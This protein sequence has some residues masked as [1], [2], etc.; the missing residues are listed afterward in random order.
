MTQESDALQYILDRWVNKFEM[1]SNKEMAARLGSTKSWVNVRGRLM[2]DGKLQASDIYEFEPTPDVIE[3]YKKIHAQIEKPLPELVNSPD[4]FVPVSIPLLGTVKAGTNGFEELV[5]D[6]DPSGDSALLPDVS[7]GQEVYSLAVVGNSM[8]TDHILPDDLL[9]V[10]RVSSAEVK[11]N[12]LIVT[13]Y[14]NEQ[15][16][17]DSEEEIKLAIQDPSNFEGPTV[18]YLSLKQFTTKEKGRLVQQTIY[19]L[20]PKDRNPDHTV[21]TRALQEGTVGRVVALHRPI[22][23]L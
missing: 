6:E 4:Y 16:N 10:E 22:R 11:E 2:K 12:D 9:I 14:L 18:K 23:R 7:P 5:L 15:F 13:K 17:L 20:S 1:P 19:R 21:T 3:R 8:V